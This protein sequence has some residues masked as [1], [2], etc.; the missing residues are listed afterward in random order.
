MTSMKEIIKEIKSGFG[1][2]N[3]KF[4]MD[5]NEVKKMLGEPNEIEKYSYTEKTENLTETWHYDD[6]E[7]SLDFDEE[8]EWKLGTISVTSEFYKLKNR[9]LIGLNKNELL[10]V[11]NELKIED[12][13]FEDWSSEESPEHTLIASDSLGINF[14]LDSEILNEIQWGPLFEDD[15]ETI[16]WPE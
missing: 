12:L 3:L 15:E 1:L 6:L 7:L 4:G 16:I 14:W 2:G 11:L 13:E 9:N 5:R 10:S 8:D